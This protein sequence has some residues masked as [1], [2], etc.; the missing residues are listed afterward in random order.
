M[1]TEIIEEFRSGFTEIKN[2]ITKTD[3]TI[4]ELNAGIQKLEDANEGLQA[5]FN[6]IRRLCMST[7]C[8]S[9]NTPQPPGMVSDRLAEYLGSTFVLQCAKSGKLEILSQSAG[10]RDA[11]LHSAR[12]TLG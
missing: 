11:L 2:G 6:K 7:Q 8:A 1:Q 3:K 12:Q 10:T 4:S 5:E 9:R